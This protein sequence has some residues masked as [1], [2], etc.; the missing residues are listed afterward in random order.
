MIQ[1]RDPQKQN[2]PQSGTD[3]NA[4]SNPYDTS[5]IKQTFWDKVAN[6]FGARSSYDIAEQ[7]R[8]QNQALW[9][10]Q[11][12]ETK[13]EELYNSAAEVKAREEAAGLNPALSGQTIGG[14]SSDALQ[15]APMQSIKPQEQPALQ[16]VEKLGTAATQAVQIGLSLATGIGQIKGIN[17]SNDMQEFDILKSMFGL[18]SDYIEKF[19]STA[20]TD[21]LTSIEDGITQLQ[22]SIVSASQD[23]VPKRYRTKFSSMVG[24]MLNSNYGKGLVSSI[25]NK[26]TPEVVKA[27]GNQNI[28]SNFSLLNGNTA[29]KPLDIFSKQ[30][31]NAQIDLYREMYKDLPKLQYNSEKGQLEYNISAFNFEKKMKVMNEKTFSVM[32]NLVSKM[33]ELT[34]TGNGF[35]KILSNSL[36]LGLSTVM[37]GLLPNVNVSSGNSWREGQSSR[38]NNHSFGITW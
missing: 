25:I 3:Y 31:T 29:L 9:N 4:V 8:L 34:L 30:I 28:L 17:L 5:Y 26:S 23:Y 35:Q 36:L 21:R 2:N 12:A 14:G 15:S 22:N 11:M 6:A 32:Q 13:R 7:E 33:E 24:T 19:T 27:S 37:M 20:Q 16:A 18:S 38:S 1:S 10:T